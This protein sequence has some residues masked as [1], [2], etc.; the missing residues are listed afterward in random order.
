MGR[1]PKGTQAVG[2]TIRWLGLAGV[3]VARV[4]FAQESDAP[5]AEE[6]PTTSAAVDSSE[7]PPDG[8]TD[9]GA[10]TQAE[11]EASPNNRPAVEDTEY[12]VRLR[13][14]EEQVNELKEKIFRSKARLLLLRETVLNGVVS[15][16]RARILHRN[17]MGSNFTLRQASYALDGSSLYN[18]TAEDNSLDE[19]REI[20]LFNGSIVPGNHNVSVFLLFQ[21]NGYGVFSYLRGYK[22]KIQSSTV[23]TAE[24]GKLTTV[25]VVAYEKGGFTTD[26]QDKPDVRYEVEVKQDVKAASTET[27]EP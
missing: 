16:A 9:A 1:V 15:G 25:K 22:F 24:E 2:T 4:A 10:S 26:L 12:A 5:P 3:L 14:L 19:Q 11:T 18:R 27:T 20:E 13:G 23:F 21:G 7:G 8:G 6:E 17:D